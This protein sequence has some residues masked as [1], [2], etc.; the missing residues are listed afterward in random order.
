MMAP[1]C[2]DCQGGLRKRLAIHTGKVLTA[3]PRQAMDQGLFFNELAASRG[4][5]GL[6]G[7]RWTMMHSKD[8]SYVNEPINEGG[9]SA[10]QA[11]QESLST[12]LDRILTKARRFTRAEAGTIYIREGNVLRFAAVQNDALA[13][14]LGEEELQR[15]LTPE[16]VELSQPSPAGFVGIHRRNPA[17]PH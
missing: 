11:D 7:R 3:Y 15:R 4:G 8:E 14:R 5:M 1:S 12:V 9:L 2:L 17:L 16:P 10:D 6:A 13:R